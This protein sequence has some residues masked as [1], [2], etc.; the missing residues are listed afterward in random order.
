MNSSP[1]NENIVIIYSLSCHSKPV[2]LEDI[3]KK[4]GKQAVL[5]PIG[6]WHGQKS[7]WERK[8]FGYQHSSKYLLLCSAEEMKSCRFGMGSFLCQTIPLKTLISLSPCLLKD[9]CD[10]M[11]LW[12]L[13]PYLLYTSTKMEWHQWT[14][15]KCSSIFGPCWMALSFPLTCVLFC[16]ENRLLPDTSKIFIAWDE[17]AIRCW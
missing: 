10:G 7:Q 2:W 5:A 8:L 13:N 3:L 14:K 9:A 11:K 16:T 1:K 15:K 4:V 6:F 17:D 12:C